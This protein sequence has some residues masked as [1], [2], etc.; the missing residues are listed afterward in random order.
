MLE[1][2][3]A[4]LPPPHPQPPHDLK[5]EKAAGEHEDRAEELRRELFD[6]LQKQRAGA[7]KTEHPLGVPS[8]SPFMPTRVNRA[9]LLHGHGHGQ[10]G[11]GWGINKTS[12]NRRGGMHGTR[13][14]GRRQSR[15][16]HLRGVAPVPPAAPR[17][18][19]PF[20][21][22]P[23]PWNE[24][25]RLDKNQV[26]EWNRKKSQLLGLAPGLDLY[27][28]NEGGGLTEMFDDDGSM[29]DRD[30]DGVEGEEGG[31]I[32]DG[33]GTHEVEQSVDDNVR[34][35]ELHDGG[36]RTPS[37]VVTM[38]ERMRGRLREQEAYIQELEDQ[39]LELQARVS[40]V[41]DA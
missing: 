36:A 25:P 1:G 32:G 6:L 9:G 19:N 33:I 13:R 5:Q 23:G 39:I 2:P 11:A 27:G 12:G 37:S 28:T 8:A 41:R 20:V 35:T 26:N 22:S 38:M 30:R 34:V 21:G 17:R 7:Q 15:Q 29:S 40:D 16:Q 14:G 4:P 24:T 31:E 3:G 10:Q 18:N